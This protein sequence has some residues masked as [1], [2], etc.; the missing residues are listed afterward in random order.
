MMNLH[1]GTVNSQLVNLNNLKKVCEEQLADP[2]ITCLKV[3][4]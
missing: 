2:I 3:K 1:S 4:C